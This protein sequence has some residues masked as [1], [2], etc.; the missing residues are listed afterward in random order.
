MSLFFEIA[1]VVLGALLAGLNGCIVYILSDHKGWLKKLDERFNDH[2]A[3]RNL[4][5]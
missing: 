5:N 3:D 1:L 2:V 4:H